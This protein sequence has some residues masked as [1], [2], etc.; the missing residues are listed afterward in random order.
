MNNIWS[1]N[2]YFQH[3]T[4]I[5]CCIEIIKICSEI[6]RKFFLIRKTLKG[7]NIFMSQYAEE[8]STYKFSFPKI[9]RKNQIKSKSCTEVGKQLCKIN[10]ISLQNILQAIQKKNMQ[11]QEVSNPFYQNYI[12][13][14]SLRTFHT[15]LIFY[16]TYTTWFYGSVL[17]FIFKKIYWTKFASY[18][19][20][21]GLEFF[22][23]LGD[24]NFQ[25]LL[26]TFRNIK[27]TLRDTP[28]HQWHI[29]DFVKGK[30]IEKCAD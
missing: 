17:N 12:P 14:N 16:V 22:D 25:A 15:D 11:I 6:D 30:D 8:F 13:L 27:I 10:C 19:L 7:K 4:V 21:L 23:E 9:W 24:N 28:T 29:Q 18:N 2:A 26:L 3:F 1:Q 5:Y 20:E